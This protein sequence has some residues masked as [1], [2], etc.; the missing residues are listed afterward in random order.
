MINRSYW[1]DSTSHLFLLQE[2]EKSEE[3]QM[4]AQS[5]KGEPEKQTNGTTTNLRSCQFV[6]KVFP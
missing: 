1:F 4:D 3:E 5:L 2:S 6:D